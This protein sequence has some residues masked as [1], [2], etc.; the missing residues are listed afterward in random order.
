[1]DWVVRCVC[2]LEEGDVACEYEMQ[3]I[4]RPFSSRKTKTVGDRKGRASTTA[5]FT[6]I[7]VKTPNLLIVSTDAADRYVSVLLSLGVWK[8]QLLSIDLKS[9]D[10][11][12]SLF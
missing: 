11:I 2:L 8:E 9:R 12:L 4:H 1:M 7:E 3:V 10:R 6:S 5:C